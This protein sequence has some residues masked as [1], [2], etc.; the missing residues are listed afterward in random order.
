MRHLQTSEYT[1]LRGC[2]VNNDSS[3]KLDMVVTLYGLPLRPQTYLTL[4][5]NGSELLH[6]ACTRVRSHID[7]LI[8][9]SQKT[10]P[11]TIAEQT[12]TPGAEAPVKI[13][14]NICNA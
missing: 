8:G 3:V 11:N 14:S 4:M 12:Y 7:A 2:R 9:C 10:P 6:I 5:A 1:Y 13:F